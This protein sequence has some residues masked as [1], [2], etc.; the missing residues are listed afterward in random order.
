M[1]LTSASIFLL[2]LMTTSMASAALIIDFSSTG[3][4][5]TLNNG[6]FVFSTQDPTGT[7]VSFDITA[8]AIIPAG[9]GANSGDISRLNS[10]LGSTVENTGTFLNVIGGVAEELVFTVSNLTGLAPGQSLQVAAVLSQNA[11]AINANQSGGFGG[12]F[13]NQAADSVTLTSD[14]MSTSVVN[15]SDDGDLGAILLNADNANATNTGNTFSHDAGNLDFTD[16][17]SVALT[18][19]NANQAIVVQGFEFA[20]VPEPATSLMLLGGLSLLFVRKRRA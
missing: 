4:N 15:Q 1:K 5:G 2:P 17:F 12:T 13:G 7:G 19:L 14:N 18:D 8:S 9:G 3:P 6:G 16:S 11:N 20:V 10:G